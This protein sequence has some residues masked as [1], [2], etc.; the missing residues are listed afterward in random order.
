MTDW[1][2]SGREK[3]ASTAA[4]PDRDRSSDDACAGKPAGVNLDGAITSGRTDCVINLQFAAVNGCTSGVE[5]RIRQPQRAGANFGE[6]AVSAAAKTAVLDQSEKIRVQIVAAYGELLAR[7]ED[8]T[9]AFDRA[10]RDAWKVVKA[11][12]QSTVV[13]NLQARCAAGRIRLKENA[14]AEASAR[15]AISNK[16]GLAGSRGYIEF[17]IAAVGMPSRAAVEGE[18]AVGC[19]RSVGEIYVTT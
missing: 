6:R 1:V 14:T 17:R 5:V 2:R 12:V 10:D 9:V 16:G 3:S 18:G 19:R 13:K 4:R 15:A 11:D 7:E 8:V